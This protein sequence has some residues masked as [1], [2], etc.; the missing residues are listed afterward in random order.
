MTIRP[1]DPARQDR[2]LLHI[3]P[4]GCGTMPRATLHRCG[5]AVAVDVGGRAV[6]GR[7]S[8]H[9]QNRAPDP[10]TAAGRSR[11]A[12][13]LRPA[14]LGSVIA[15][16][17]LSAAAC[18]GTASATRVSVHANARAGGTSRSTIASTTTTSPPP[19]SST[20]STL[21]L[22]GMTIGVD[23]GH[24]GLNYENPQI[25]GAQV[26]NG[27]EYE[28][29]NT[30][31]T[32][33][34]SGFTEAQ[35]NWNVGQYLTTDLQAAGA[36]V[37]LTRSSNDGVGPCV[38]VRAQILNTTDLGIAIHADGGPPTGR[39]FAV[40]E[41]VADGTNNSVIGPSAAF[42]TDVRNTFA[43]VTGMPT[44][45]YDGVDGVQPRDDLAGEN[46][47]TVPYVLIECGN[48]RNA[49]DA[50][51]L[52]TTAFQQQAASALEQAIA[53]YVAQSH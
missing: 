4:N 11:S 15:L 43:A 3:H 17:V 44:S 48:M 38:N 13:W 20:T 30:T 41:P 36:K 19:P 53:A 12:T 35:F 14:S 45:T 6:P 42:A 51:L 34:D 10:V 37:V 27:R 2:I 23:P 24:N 33:T 1:T 52:V 50:A 25:I 18:G 22:A 28:D 5:L 9:R 21:P 32:E 39:G 7:R 8:E 29:C 26:W 47:T 31:G 16:L 46:L 49:T 40:L